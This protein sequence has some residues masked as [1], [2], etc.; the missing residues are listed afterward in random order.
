MKRSAINRCI[1]EAS[2]FFVRNSFFLPPFADWT[3][4]EWQKRG[5]E[6]NEL[7]MS[8][9]GWD[10]TDFTSGKFDSLGLTL[11]TLRNG[12]AGGGGPSKTYAE[13]IMFVR[14]RQVTPFH[15]HVRKTEDIINR[16]GKGAGRLAVQLYNSDANDGFSQSPVSVVCD[17]I[18]RQVE[19]G[20]TI[21][22]GPGESI[23]LTP[24]LYH[25]FYAVDGHGLIGEVSSFNDDETDN[26]FKDP[27]PR[28]PVVVG[29]E[30]PL[31]LLCTEYPLM[32]G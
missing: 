10:I 15:Y 20:A 32:R 31:R 11:F 27:L 17:G 25:T 1:A 8:R 18:R 3:P 23:T 6:T 9:L 13:K 4:E 28:F 29:D 22:L 12:L 14:E 2:E 16:G 5:G 7:Q 24:Y 30:P 26:H 21:I 19:P